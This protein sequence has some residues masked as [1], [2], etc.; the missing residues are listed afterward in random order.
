MTDKIYIPVIPL[1]VIQSMSLNDSYILLLDATTAGLQVPVLIG[2]VEAQ[3]LIMACEQRQTRRPLTHNL[4][5]NVLNAY[6]ILL[7]RVNIDRFE[8]GIFY[9]TLYLDDGCVSQ[10]IDS[11]TSDAIVLALMQQC[12]IY[13]NAQVLEET[14]MKPGA[15]VDNMPQKSDTELS[16]AELEKRLH[17]CEEQEDYEQAALIQQ[18]IDKLQNS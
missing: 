2:E 18:Q 17:E 16:L 6:G 10:Q 13:I 4:L 14:G 3:A 9:S 11:R 8:E 5:N 7:K 12:D 15:L 1:Q